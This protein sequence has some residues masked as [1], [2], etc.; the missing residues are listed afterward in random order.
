MKSEQG[1]ILANYEKMES[2]VREAASNGAQIISLPELWSSGYHLTKEEFFRFSESKDGPTTSLGMKL[3]KELSVVLIIPFPEL[4]NSKHK[5]YI[6]CAV[7]DANGE[8]TGIHRKAFLWGN[9]RERF[10]PGPFSFSVYNTSVARIGVLICY[11]IEFPEPARLLSLAGAELIVCPSVW[12][13][14]A[15]QRWQIQLPARALDNTCFVMGTNT[16]GEGACGRS[17]IVDPSGKILTEGSVT[18][19]MIVTSQIEFDKIEE[20]RQRIPYLKDLPI[21]LIPRG[22][23]I[24]E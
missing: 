9:E 13:I 23:N 6:S 12:S 10:S 17:M 11:D 24:L 14:E 7:I 22:A 8:V 16:V 3:A 15:E 2:M 5:V 1:N 20:I 19:E 18:E 4:D 21:E